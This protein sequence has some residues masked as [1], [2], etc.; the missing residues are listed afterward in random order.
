[1]KC[2]KEINSLR[3]KLA[4]PYETVSVRTDKGKSN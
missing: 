1:M 3:R 4:T 2:K